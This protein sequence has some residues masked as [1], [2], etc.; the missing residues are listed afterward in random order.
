[1]LRRCLA[2]DERTVRSRCRGW[3]APG[4]KLEPGAFS[5]AQIECVQSQEFLN[6]R[7]AAPFH[8]GV[9]SEEQNPRFVEKYNPVSKLFGE[10]HI[11]SDDHASEVKLN[12]QTLH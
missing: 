11:M 1:M 3:C 4:S 7:L 8:V 2:N 6:D 5:C 10:P 12:L 9:S